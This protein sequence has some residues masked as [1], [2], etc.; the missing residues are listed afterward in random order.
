[1]VFTFEG[2]QSVNLSQLATYSQKHC[3]IRNILISKTWYG[4]ECLTAIWQGF[5]STLPDAIPDRK[6]F[7]SIIDDCIIHS[8][9]EGYLSHLMAL[10]KALIRNG[11]KISPRKCQLFKQKF[12]YTQLIKDK[13]PYTTPLRSKVDAKWLE[14]NKPAKKCKVFYVK[15]L[16]DSNL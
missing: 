16:D 4:F 7:L 14:P 3:S 13:T 10:T 1:M 5:I 8:S 12:T 6:H 15:N 11:L 9:R 2:L